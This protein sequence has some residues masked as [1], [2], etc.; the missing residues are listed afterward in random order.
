M[1]NGGVFIVAG[2]KERIPDTGLF[3][4]FRFILLSYQDVE[5]HKRTN[6]LS[7]SLLWIAQSVED[8]SAFIPFDYPDHTYLRVVSILILVGKLEMW[9]KRLV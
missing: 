2:G 3:I 4:D 7:I 9:K 1:D 8:K 5:N 6:N